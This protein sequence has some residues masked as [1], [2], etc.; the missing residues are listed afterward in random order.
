MYRARIDDLF[1][2]DAERHAR[3]SL[4]ACGLL[5]DFSKQR[6]SP[7]SIE[8]LLAHARALHVPAHME[9][10][11]GGE[12]VNF[13]EGRA[14]LH[15]ALRHR[16]E[17]SY[18]DA[19]RDVMPQVRAVQERMR[20]LCDALHRGEVRGFSG[21]PLRNVVNIGIGGSDLGPAMVCEALRT[22]HRPGMQAHFVSNVES[23]E[24]ARVL[25]V[26][27]PEE[28]LFI[29]VSKT[30]STRETLINAASARE[31]LVRAAGA[32]SAVARHFVAATA[33][34]DRAGE[35]GID[36]IACSSSGTG[37]VGA[38]RSGRRRASPS[39]PLPAWTSSRNCSRA[40]PTWTR[41][42]AT[43]RL[44]RTPRC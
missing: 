42:S 8:L 13:T 2:R 21:R 26:S 7:E 40:P 5:V 31:W 19:G 44:H 36:P 33:R 41:T 6:V 30:F 9:A 22:R 15:C 12:N 25:E 18:P 3:L 14:A 10:L 32:S 29:V 23:T 16:G 24:L 39:P 27:D 43:H 1:T 20:A 35:F 28:T 38:T 11:L 17:E 37:W 4:E 34:V